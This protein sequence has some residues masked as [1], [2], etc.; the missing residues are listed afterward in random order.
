MWLGK[1]D[2]VDEVS[3]N[4]EHGSRFEK[5]LLE[6]HFDEGE[7]CVPLPIFCFL[8][9]LKNALEILPHGL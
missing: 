4:F 1:F 9:G 5:I 6:Q 2:G 7:Q 3:D 8:V